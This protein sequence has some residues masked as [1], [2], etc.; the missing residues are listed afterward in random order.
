VGIGIFNH[1]CSCDLDLDPMI[2]IYELDLSLLEIYSMCKNELLMSRL[3]KVIVLQTYRQ[4]NISQPN[5]IP[6]HFV[7]GQ[8]SMKR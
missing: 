1:V 8:K 3:L 6:R 7:G 2:F 4:T 5:Y